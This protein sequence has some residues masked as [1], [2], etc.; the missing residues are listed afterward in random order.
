MRGWVAQAASA[1]A[2]DMVL[3]RDEAVRSA[4]L[5][6]MTLMLAAQGIGLGSCAMVGFDA[7]RLSQEF[8][9]ASTDL[10]VILVTVG[11]AAEGNWPQKPRKPVPEVV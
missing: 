2:E 1:H 5:A 7:M 3:Q 4:S 10:P 6:A 8:G 9:L 11:Y